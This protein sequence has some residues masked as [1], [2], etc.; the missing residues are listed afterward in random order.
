[1]MLHV[2]TALAVAHQEDLRAQARQ[3]SERRAARRAARA[4]RSTGHRARPAR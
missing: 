4:E 2:S 3:D 1:M